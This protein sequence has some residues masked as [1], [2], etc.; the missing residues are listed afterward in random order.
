MNSSVNIGLTHHLKAT[1]HTD[2]AQQKGVGGEGDRVEEHTSVMH[3][4]M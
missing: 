4:C 1:H 3:A 2:G